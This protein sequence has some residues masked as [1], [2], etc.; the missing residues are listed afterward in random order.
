MKITLA[1]SA[2]PVL[3]AAGGRVL[4]E[5]AAAVPGVVIPRDGENVSV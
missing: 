5:L 4:G 2:T 1:R 3:E